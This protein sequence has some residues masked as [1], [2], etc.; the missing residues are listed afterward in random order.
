MQ[1]EMASCD[2]REHASCSSPP[3]LANHEEKRPR[4]LQTQANLN[5]IQERLDHFKQNL[6]HD[7][8]METIDRWE[9]DSMRKIQQVAEEARQTLRECLTQHLSSLKAGL[10]DLIGTIQ[11]PTEKNS[12]NERSVDRW[13]TQ[14]NRLKTKTTQPPDLI[15]EQGSATLIHAL[16]V[17]MPVRVSRK[18]SI[19]VIGLF[20]RAF[21]HGCSYGQM[22]ATWTVCRWRSRGWRCNQP[23]IRSVRCLCRRTGKVTYCRPL[24]PSHRRM[25]PQ[26]LWW[27]SSGWW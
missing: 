6:A 11:Q 7:S 10:E 24:E 26:W 25:Q 8:S 12:S 5:F 16:H 27:K 17:R 9:Q 15:I 23:A 2:L 19:F 21:L 20:E 22:D 14:L 4:Q 3:Q 18:C 1:H 13:S